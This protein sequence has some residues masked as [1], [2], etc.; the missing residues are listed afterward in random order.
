[1]ADY[2]ENDPRLA[3]YKPLT[4]FKERDRDRSSRRIRDMPWGKREEAGIIGPAEMNFGTV[5][6]NGMSA[7]QTAVVMNTG[8]GDLPIKGISAVG[9]F[10]IQSNCPSSL[11]PG[12]SCEIVIIF[13][14]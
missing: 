12:E 9:D 10:L 1:M 13:N 5:G 11:A 14:P 2:D 6:I 8:Y 4:Q 7:S 3:G